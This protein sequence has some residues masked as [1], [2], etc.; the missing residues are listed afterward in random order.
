MNQL[1]YLNA[2]QSMR[3]F[4]QLCVCF[5]IFL[6]FMLCVSRPVYAE[7][8]DPVPLN[9]GQSLHNI[10]DF[11]VYAKGKK[12]DRNAAVQAYRGGSFAATFD[13]IAAD[14]EM[15][16]SYWAVVPL[17]HTD[18]D[19][20]GGPS[21][22]V[23]TSGLEAAWQLDIYLVRQ[24]G[25][26]QI[27]LEHT[28]FEGTY[29]AQNH[30]G[31]RLK[32][33]GFALSPG[34]QVLLLVK[35]EKLFKAPPQI[36][37]LTFDELSNYR[38]RF[39]IETALFYGICFFALLSM[40]LFHAATK[41]RL[42]IQYTALFTFYLLVL[43]HREGFSVAYLYPGNAAFDGI[44]NAILNA[45]MAMFGLYVALS[46]TPEDRKSHWLSHLFR[47]LLF[48]TPVLFA[49]QMLRLGRL[50]YDLILAITVISLLL[51]LVVLNWWR[52]KSELSPMIPRIALVLAIALFLLVQFLEYA[53]LSARFLTATT[54][55]KISW[56]IGG[57]L[58][59][60]MLTNHVVR[61]RLDREQLLAERVEVL[62]RDAEMKQQLLESERNYSRARDQAHMR[63]RQLASASHDI[64]QPLASLR[65]HLDRLAPTLDSEIRSNINETM[66]YLD[67]LSNDYLTETREGEESDQLHDSG[68]HVAEELKPYPLSLVFGAVDQ[69]FSETAISKGLRLK[70][71]NSSIETAVPPLVLMRILSNLTSNAIKATDKGRILIGARRCSDGAMISIIDTG[72][73]M[74]ADEIVRFRAAY[75]KGDGSPGE[76]LG[77]A[78]CNKLAL[79]N[80]L[81]IKIESQPSKGTEISI[82]LPTSSRGDEIL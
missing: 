10:D 56:I 75:Q 64:R 59:M 53:G 79:E 35:V 82:I 48:V 80:N 18:T 42:G 21:T 61:V 57:S 24:D 30:V 17:I 12:R 4:R 27:L 46:A 37:I 3:T 9:P 78:I 20:D 67:Q 34:E 55:F 60:Y 70:V 52:K 76:G 11:M 65:L 43:L 22:W 73:G 15:P 33:T 29:N 7:V 38:E 6:A 8:A 25:T 47:F 51:H 74:D 13:D 58:T 40:L 49:I 41:H 66:A 5:S 1:Q 23:I 16:D 32:S 45:G 71:V 26:Y 2:N 36:D 68:F 72:C 69:M 44:F 19:A 14:L 54:Y 31:L 63:Q 81:A 50:A 77:L 39:A 28:G 62:A